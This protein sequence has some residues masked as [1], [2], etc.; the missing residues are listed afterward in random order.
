MAPSW[1][2][3]RHR[4]SAGR[5]VPV[6]AFARPSTGVSRNRVSTRSSSRL[7][8]RVLILRAARDW[9]R[10]PTG[11]CATGARAFGRR[12]TRPRTPVA[13]WRR[14]VRG[15]L[16]RRVGPSGLD[17]SWR[18]ILDD[19]EQRVAVVGPAGGGICLGEP[20][21]VI[22][23]PYE[24]T[25]RFFALDCLLVVIDRRVEVARSSARRPRAPARLPM[26]MR[27]R[28]DRTRRSANGASSSSRSAPSS[29]SPRRYAASLSSFV[30]E[31]QL[32][33]RGQLRGT[34]AARCAAT[35]PR[36]SSGVARVAAASDK[37]QNRRPCRSAA[38]GLPRGCSSTSHRP[39]S[40]RPPL[41]RT[42]PGLPPGSGLLPGGR[43]V[44]AS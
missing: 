14:Y 37:T 5:G 33:S 44:A 31:S 17:P 42:N 22:G 10:V 39:R 36:A 18:L 6:I 9:W 15:R 23:R 27:A 35:S 21:P 40:R 38:A 28:A 25:G 34:P 1:P 24:R 13:R 41:P 26:H 29:R 30:A 20:A 16:G 11:P 2:L 3:R 19:R 8:T 12:L 7:G 43:S 32:V 4:G